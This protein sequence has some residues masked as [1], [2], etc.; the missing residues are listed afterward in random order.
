MV[1]ERK[2]NK[3][4]IF[5]VLFFLVFGQIAFAQSS[6]A[7]TVI[8]AGIGPEFNM[9]SRE[10]FAG[11]IALSLDYQLPIEAIRLSAGLT[12]TA[13]YNF[14][15]T[16]VLETTAMARWYFL[17][18]DHTGLFAQVDLGVHL[19]TERDVS[20]ILFEGGIRAGYRLLLGDSFYIEPYGRFGYP[21]F[22]G[23][24]VLA[25]MRIQISPNSPGNGN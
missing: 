25:G 8:S 22:M 4:I 16:F 10:N 19:I 3:N 15:D 12:V 7:N 11:G 5:L 13:S 20:V 6:E 23:I 18:A 14:T 2:V 1:K 24:G 21:Y 17:G 9:N